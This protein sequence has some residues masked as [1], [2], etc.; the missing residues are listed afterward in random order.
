MAGA[1]R[2][3]RIRR[4]VCPDVEDQRPKRLIRFCGADCGQCATYERFV[5]G[6][7][8]GLVNQQTGYRCCWLPADYPQGTA[9]AIATCCEGRGLLF[10]A[11]CDQFNRCE[12]V[13]AFYAQPGYERLRERMLEALGEAKAQ[14][15]ER[16]R[17]KEAR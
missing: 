1:V 2:A 14:T 12:L 6:D 16:E 8:S 7:T 10:C 15:R 17:R 9:C 11:A 5:A 13:E 3:G 4:R